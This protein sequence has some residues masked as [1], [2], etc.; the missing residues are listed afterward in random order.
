MYFFKFQHPTASL[1]K[2][3]GLRLST[4]GFSHLSTETK[5][6]DD[7]IHHNTD[8]SEKKNYFIFCPS[9]IERG[10]IIFKS[11]HQINS[12]VGA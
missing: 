11:I 9:F 10:K 1:R 3:T 4:Y 8:L 2:H 5:Q 6:N 12:E 7:L